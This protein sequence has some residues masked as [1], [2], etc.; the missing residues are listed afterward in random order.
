[1]NCLDC[2]ATGETLAAVGVCRDCG[3]GLCL[4]H[5]V[6]SPLYLTRTMALAREVN[7]EPPGRVLRCELCHTAFE[8]AARYRPAEARHRVVARGY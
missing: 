7:V 3:S 6:T 2:A 1:M 8:A 4:D 5:V